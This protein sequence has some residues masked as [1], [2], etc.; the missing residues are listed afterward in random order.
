[1]RCN[2]SAFKGEHY[3]SSVLASDFSPTP[4]K[5]SSILGEGSEN[6][7]SQRRRWVFRKPR[8]THGQ[9]LIDTDSGQRQRGLVLRGET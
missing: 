7:T 2:G 5:V 1:M 6:K 9:L 4:N 8:P 3:I